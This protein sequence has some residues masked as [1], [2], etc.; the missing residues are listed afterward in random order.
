MSTEQNTEHA[1]SHLY[2]QHHGKGGAFVIGADGKRVPDTSAT[3]TAGD[4]VTAPK[5]EPQQPAEV[6]PK[7]TTANKP[8][9]DNAAQE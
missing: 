4:G 6:A 8:R 3:V 7:P 1:Q 5:A 9:R 2:D